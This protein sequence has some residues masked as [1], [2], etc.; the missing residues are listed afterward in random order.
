[1]F[2]LGIASKAALFLGSFI[3]EI[4]LIPSIIRASLSSSDSTDNIAISNSGCVTTLKK[5]R[6][7]HLYVI[8]GL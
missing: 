5:F 3:L 2:G 1:M 6:I 4:C 8:N 7:L